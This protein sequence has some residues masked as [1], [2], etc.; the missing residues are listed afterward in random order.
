MEI[1]DCGG[2][3]EG[4]AV[5]GEKLTWKRGGTNLFVELEKLSLDRLLV[6]TREVQLMK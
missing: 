2:S 5:G 3:E 6:V 1:R 4:N